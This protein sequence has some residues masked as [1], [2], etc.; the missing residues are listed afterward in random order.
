VIAIE[1]D[2]LQGINMVWTYNMAIIACGRG[3][4]AAEAVKVLDNMI[5]AGLTPCLTTYTALMSLFCRVGA[6][7]EACTVF[8]GMKAAGV[9]PNTI[10]YS[11]LINGC[12]KAGNLEAALLYFEEM[13]VRFHTGICQIDIYLSHGASLRT[14]ALRSASVHGRCLTVQQG[15][16]SF[17]L[18][19][20]SHQWLL[21]TRFCVLAWPLVPGSSPCNFGIRCGRKVFGPTL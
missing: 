5:D 3:S 7:S 9:L 20:V 16:Y 4:R 10:T 2:G 17:R 19:A 13:L 6:L 14:W 12:E 18:R 8:E 21:I 15:F 11:S 1:V